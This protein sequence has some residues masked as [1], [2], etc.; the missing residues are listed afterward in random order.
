M[1]FADIEKKAYCWLGML[2][3]MRLVAVLLPTTSISNK[4]DYGFTW[5][6]S[7]SDVKCALW[8]KSFKQATSTT[9]AL[10]Q[11]KLFHKAFHIMLSVTDAIWKWSNRSLSLGTSFFSTAKFA[12]GSKSGAGTALGH[13][14]LQTIKW[15]EGV[16]CGTSNNSSRCAYVAHWTAC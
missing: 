13:A 9:L 8:D 5:P 10:K 4:F 6:D 14:N 1:I 15:G 12:T 16:Q 7:P 11:Q 3:K 2:N